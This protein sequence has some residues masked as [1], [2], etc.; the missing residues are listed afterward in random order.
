[1]DQE[2]LQPEAGYGDGEGGDDDDEVDVVSGGG[3]AADSDEQGSLYEYD[4][5]R[6]NEQRDEDDYEGLIPDEEEEEGGLEDLGYANQTEWGIGS[7]QQ[8]RQYQTLMSIPPSAYA[9]HDSLPGSLLSSVGAGPGQPPRDD[10]GD[11]WLG[12][13]ASG[14][15]AVGGER[16]EAAERTGSRAGGARGLMRRLDL[17]GSDDD[18]DTMNN[19]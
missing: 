10:D 2:Q 7:M 14:G 9:H 12:R 6:N 13:R 3:G 1:V 5:L 8:P 4:S 11:H 17:G 16:G 19:P 18:L 15:S